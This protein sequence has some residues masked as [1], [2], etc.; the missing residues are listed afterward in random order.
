MDEELREHIRSLAE[1]MEVASEPLEASLLSEGMPEDLAE[2][3]AEVVG[4][5]S[6]FAEMTEKN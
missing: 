2:A 4:E 5:T 3:V 1:E 6:R